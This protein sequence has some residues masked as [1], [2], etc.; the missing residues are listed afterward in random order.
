MTPVDLASLAPASP[1]VAV[2]AVARQRA[3]I[4][5]I[6]S[7]HLGDRDKVSLISWKR[8]EARRES[9]Y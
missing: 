7:M 9:G 6:G 3:Q 2:L 1:A 5:R 4:R 8:M